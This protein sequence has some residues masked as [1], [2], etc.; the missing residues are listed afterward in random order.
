MSPSLSF[1][2]YSIVTTVSIVGLISYVLPSFIFPGTVIAI[3][4]WFVG[5]YYLATSRDMKRLNS[6]SRSPIYVQFNESVNGVTT[7]RAF[8][9]QYRF[10]AENHSLIDNNNRP[11]L[12]MWATNRWL[13]ARVE[14]VGAFVSFCTGFVMVLARD[15]VDP[16]MAGLALSY[17]LTFVFHILWVVRMYAINEMNMNSIER[18]HEYLDVD[19]EPPAHIPH[20]CPPASWPETGKIKVENLVMQYAPES[21]AVLRNVSFETRPKE[22][23]GIV[24]RTGSGKFFKSGN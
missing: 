24:G 21:P 12:W 2:L 3:I 7:I 16:G 19:Q 14:T 8:G 15:W 9:S 4:Y 23:I 1:L 17:S 13:H 18:L 10:I 5:A 22:K 20:T 6:V 11:F